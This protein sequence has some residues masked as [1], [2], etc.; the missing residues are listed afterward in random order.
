MPNCPR[1][2][3]SLSTLQA[4][5]YHMY[6]RKKRCDHPQ[7]VCRKCRVQLNQWYPCACND[8]LFQFLLSDDEPETNVIRTEKNYKIINVF[9]E[10]D[11][12]LA[13]FKYLTAA[14]SE[15]DVFSV[16]P[17]KACGPRRCAD[18]MF[19]NGVVCKMKMFD[20][21]GLIYFRKIR[22]CDISLKEGHGY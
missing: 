17:R 3:K 1:C 22:W 19:S 12:E 10:T 5:N 7:A 6:Q 15:C 18:V 4:L 9:D 21:A 20:H 14:S 8:K 2:G 11:P 13:G 16:N